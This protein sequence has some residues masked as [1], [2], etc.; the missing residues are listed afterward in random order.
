MILR[1]GRE[2]YASQDLHDVSELTGFL[3]N[4]F[5]SYNFAVLWLSTLLI[6][7]GS[8]QGILGEI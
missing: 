3:Y 1:L 2:K 7:T 6:T 8:G 5:N 4:A